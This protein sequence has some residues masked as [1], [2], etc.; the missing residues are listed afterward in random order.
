MEKKDAIM[1]MGYILSGSLLQIFNGIDFGFISA[2]IAMMGFGL[3]FYGLSNLK[4]LIDAHG[5]SAITLLSVGAVIGSIGAL[6]DLIPFIGGIIAMVFYLIAFIV[7]LIGL[8]Q[9]K[10]SRTFGSTGKSGFNFLILGM[11]MISLQILMNI[12]PFI[13]SY[14]ASI[15]TLLAIILILLGWLKVLEDLAERF[16]QSEK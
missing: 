9:F 3:Y 2:L 6:I 4:P 1:A 8:I 14:I 5:Q 13:G 15:F 16:A 12:I 7:E 11:V 10:S